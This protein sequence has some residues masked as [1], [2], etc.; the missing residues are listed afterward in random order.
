MDLE[1]EI[2]K[3]IDDY[4]KECT[5]KQCYQEK[6]KCKCDY[7]V[8]RKKR[9]KKLFVRFAESSLPEKAKQSII[10]SHINIGRNACIDEIQEKINKYKED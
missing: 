1:K 7:I 10:P 2:S 5:Y 3:Y 9:L 6:G 8:K 4:Y